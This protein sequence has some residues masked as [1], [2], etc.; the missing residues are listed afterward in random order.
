[1]LALRYDRAVNGLKINKALFTPRQQGTKKSLGGFGSAQWKPAA[2]RLGGNMLSVSEPR[3]MIE[4]CIFWALQVPQRRIDAKYAT[5]HTNMN[6][7]E[8]C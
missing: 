3:C 6:E 2:N 7:C 1:M 4:W 5:V 8:L